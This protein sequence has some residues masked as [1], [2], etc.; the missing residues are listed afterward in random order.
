MAS[1]TSSNAI[2]MLSV[3]KVY[4]VPQQ[5]EDW[6]TDNIYD[7]QPSVIAEI[8]MG[9]DGVLTGGLVYTA[10]PITYHLQADSPSCAVFD[11]W[12]LAQETYGDLYYAFGSLTLNALGIKW[13]M[14][15]GILT[16]WQRIPS[17]QRTLQP[18]TAI[19]TWQSVTPQPSNSLP[20]N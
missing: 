10:Q 7:L 1:I 9:A 16:Q 18:R 20:Q 12:D 3:D 15:K 19:I 11:A 6:A 8:R 2:I 17:G 13:S 14:T 4:N 5:L